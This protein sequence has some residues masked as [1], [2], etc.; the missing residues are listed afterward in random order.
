MNRKLIDFYKSNST[1][2]KWHKTILFAALMFVL[3]I[4]LLVKRFVYSRNLM[5]VICTI[6]VVIF[7][8]LLLFVL[9]RFKTNKSIANNV[10][11]VFGLTT[12]ANMG[13]L[14]SGYQYIY[15]IISAIISLG[16]AI[17]LHN[18]I[19][20]RILNDKFK[21]K[22]LSNSVFIV[23]STM[24]VLL[25]FFIRK[26]ESNLLILIGSGLISIFAFFES[27]MLF[28]QIFVLLKFNDC[29]QFLD[30]S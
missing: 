2:L 18:R 1:V 29:T 5:Y 23:S 6:D 13:Y 10:L 12:L 30:Q 11:W 27:I 14:V 3:Q 17:L 4:T 9:K 20:K 21:A 16:I 28:Y 26:I 15:V 22:V 25:N 24:A 7:L 8:F 19:K